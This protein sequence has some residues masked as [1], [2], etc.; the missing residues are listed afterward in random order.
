MTLAQHCRSA[1]GNGSGRGI[2]AHRDSVSGPTFAR[3]QDPPRLIY[4]VN[5]H[6]MTPF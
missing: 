5:A 3:G 1:A 6:G 4:A 2:G